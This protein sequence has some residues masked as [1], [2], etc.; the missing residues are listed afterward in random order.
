MKSPYN[1]Q[2]ELDH[3]TPHQAAHRPRKQSRTRERA[4]AYHHRVK[5][6]QQFQNI[7]PISPKLCHQYHLNSNNHLIQTLLLP[8]LNLRHFQYQFLHAV[9]IPF[10]DDAISYHGHHF[11][12]QLEDY[13][14]ELLLVH[15]HQE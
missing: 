5:I 3:I 6:H 7:P 2:S 8:F 1:T 12:H 15:F 11:D 13:H 4:R 9:P 10:V 14:P